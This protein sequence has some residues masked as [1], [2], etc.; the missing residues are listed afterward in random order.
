LPSALDKIFSYTLGWYSLF[1]FKFIG[2]YNYFLYYWRIK[3]AVMA[4]INPFYR[5]NTVG[6]SNKKA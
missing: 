2:I 1:W 3:R 5:K 6:Y 4:Q